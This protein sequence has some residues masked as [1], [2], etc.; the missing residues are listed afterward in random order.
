MKGMMSGMGVGMGT[1]VGMMRGMGSVVLI[2]KGIKGGDGDSNR[3][4]DGGSSSSEYCDSD[5]N[6]DG[7]DNG[8]GMMTTLVV[9]R[10]TGDAIKEAGRC[11]QTP[12]LV[13]GD[14]RCSPTNQP[15]QGSLSMVGKVGGGRGSVCFGGWL[16]Q[17][18]VHGAH[19]QV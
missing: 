15:A 16:E 4:G 14:S 13:A 1:W 6:G 8:S 9:N 19:W 17:T 10:G 18:P 7:D 11:H 3:D 12:E 2:K 5:R